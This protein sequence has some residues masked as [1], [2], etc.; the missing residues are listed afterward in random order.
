MLTGE[1]PGAEGEIHRRAKQAKWTPNIDAEGMPTG[2]TCEGK[3]W[4]PKR[5]YVVLRRFFVYVID[6]RSRSCCSL[7]CEQV[8]VS[9]CLCEQVNYLVWSTGITYLRIYYDFCKS[10][11]AAHNEIIQCRALSECGY[12]PSPLPRHTWCRAR[13]YRLSQAEYWSPAGRAT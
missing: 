12:S 6:H 1:W 10:W 3:I 2:L 5:Q 11:P 8:L 13:R 4:W 7:L 9:A